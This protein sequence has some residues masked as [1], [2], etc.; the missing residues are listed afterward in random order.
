M[1]TI[2]LGVII[3]MVLS[4]LLAFRAKHDLEIKVLS[5]MLGGALGLLVGLI[6]AIILPSELKDKRTT[7]NIMCLQDNNIVKGN[8]TLGCGQVSGEWYYTF[9]QINPDGGIVLKQ[10]PCDKSVIQYSDKAPCV[11]TFTKVQT[12]NWINLFSVVAVTGLKQ[13]ILYIPKGSI[14][15]FF[16]IDAE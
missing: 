7:D 9:Y 2:I 4:V 13:Y 6:V 3:G 15:P 11:V 5:G 12:D 1:I 14:Q 16:N 8:F 10:I